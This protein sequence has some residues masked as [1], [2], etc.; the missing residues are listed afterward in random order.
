MAADRAGKT[1]NDHK[2]D[3]S[4]GAARTTPRGAVF[5]AGQRAFDLS[6]SHL[7]AGRLQQ[8]RVAIAFMPHDSAWPLVVQAAASMHRSESTQ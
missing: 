4:T 3:F 2:D 8:A 7:G 1:G 5:D 6:K